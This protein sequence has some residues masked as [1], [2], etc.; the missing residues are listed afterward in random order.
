MPR[1]VNVCEGITASDKTAK[2]TVRIGGSGVADV[3]ARLAFPAL[4]ARFKA[5]RSTIC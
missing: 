3:V 1:L 2:A 5:W 4:L